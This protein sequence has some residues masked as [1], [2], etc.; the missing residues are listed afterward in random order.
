MESSTDGV[1]MAT[2][3]TPATAP[4]PAPTD[5]CRKCRTNTLI[6]Q[7]EC[8]TPVARHS[9]TCSRKHEDNDQQQF[10]DLGVCIECNNIARYRRD[11]ANGNIYCPGAPRVHTCSK[12]E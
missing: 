7:G 10:V 12:G 6:K 5:F 3:T 4:A 8:M 2:A 9:S 11:Y 1:I